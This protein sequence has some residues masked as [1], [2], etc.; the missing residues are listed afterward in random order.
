[1]TSMHFNTTEPF[2]ASVLDP[3]ARDWHGENLV[4]TAL[5]A[6]YG[7]PAYVEG[8]DTP[9]GSYSM[10]VPLDAEREVSVWLPES[11]GDPFYVQCAHPETGEPSECGE[12]PADIAADVIAEVRRFIAGL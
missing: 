3:H 5:A 7:A 8:P 12:I 1:M 6:T 10:R 4:V 11:T 9:G 2:P